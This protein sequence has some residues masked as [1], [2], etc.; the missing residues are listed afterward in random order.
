VLAAIWRK[1]TFAYPPTFSHSEIGRRSPKADLAGR[2][3]NGRLKAFEVKLRVAWH[4]RYAPA[5]ERL[6]AKSD[7]FPPRRLKIPIFAIATIIFC[8]AQ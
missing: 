1:Q 3:P 8:A 2:Q 6:N 7:W 4:H 5:P